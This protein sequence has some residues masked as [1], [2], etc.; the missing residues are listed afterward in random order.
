M[1]RNIMVL[2]TSSDCGACIA[3]RGPNGKPSEKK[4]VTRSGFAWDH[5][6]IK[7]ILDNPNNHSIP[8][9]NMLVELFYQGGNDANQLLQVS[10]YHL[11]EDQYNRVFNLY[12]IIF[13]K[14]KGGRLGFRVEIDGTFNQVATDH[15]KDIYSREILTPKVFNDI[16][17]EVNKK[18]PKILDIIK[19]SKLESDHLASIRELVTKGL[20]SSIKDY[21]EDN[22]FPEYVTFKNFVNTTIPKHIGIVFPSFS[23]SWT[24]F[25]QNVWL[26]SLLYDKTL[27]GVT[28]SCQTVRVEINNNTNPKRKYYRNVPNAKQLNP[29]I[30]LQNYEEGKFSL[31]IPD[32]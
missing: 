13:S 4:I 11:I 5:S 25:D 16:L 32:N 6:T 23:P 27:Y 8:R 30:H 3:L 22:V 26:E 2:K 18:K 29:L 12:R 15:V 31:S 14:Y 28:N 17:N 10:E 20:N 9:V 24:L 19:N 21:I 1:S 7:N